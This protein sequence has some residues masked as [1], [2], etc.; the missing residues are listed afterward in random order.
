MR[1]EPHAYNAL[2]FDNNASN[3][4]SGKVRHLRHLSG[5][6]KVSYLSRGVQSSQTPSSK[7]KSQYSRR[8]S[9]RLFS[10]RRPITSRSAPS[11][12]PNRRSNSSCV[13]TILYLTRLSVSNPRFVSEQR[14]SAVHTTQTA[15]QSSI[16][17]CVYQA[18]FFFPITT[19]YRN[20]PTSSRAMPGSKTYPYLSTNMRRM[21]LKL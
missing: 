12:A 11:L 1:T 17:L 16:R 4:G 9:N 5:V 18:T 20:S 21:A 6:L 3:S 14:S 7:R 10:T 19:Q 2:S 13:H 15:E 8:N